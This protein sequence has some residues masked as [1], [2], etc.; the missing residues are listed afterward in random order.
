V[1]VVIALAVGRA[2]QIATENTVSRA[3]G[4][5]LTEVMDTGYTRG[6]CSA[7]DRHGNR[8][9]TIDELH[10]LQD[11]LCPDLAEPQQSASS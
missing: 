7:L 11:Q 2:L 9:L 1:I 8:T 5:E 4:S 10:D 3:D 6:A